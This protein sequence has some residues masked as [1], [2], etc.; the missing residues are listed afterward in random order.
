MKI[1]AK[2]ITQPAKHKRGPISEIEKE[3][4][5]VRGR[6][7]WT[8]DNPMHNPVSKA[9]VIAKMKGRKLPA[10]H[11]FRNG[12]WKGKKLS[13]ERKEKIRQNSPRELMSM[14]KT[15]VPS[16]HTEEQKRLN[17]ERMKLNNPMHNPELA[18]KMIE[19]K[20]TN[21]KVKANQKRRVASLN[22]EAVKKTQFQTN[23]LVTPEIE[24]EICK[25]YKENCSLDKIGKKYG[26][27]RK[28]TIRKILVKN[29]I[30]IRK[31]TDKVYQLGYNF[32]KNKCKEV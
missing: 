3:Q 25:M 4:R 29:N 11:P 17:N 32:H 8:K 30:P 23:I 31:R 18:K 26:L 7:R 5:R 21:R 16:N 12:F 28:R 10:D 24:E 6:E 2:K 22:N 13:P 20:K 9:K 14:I 19:S 15:G 1:I 27:S